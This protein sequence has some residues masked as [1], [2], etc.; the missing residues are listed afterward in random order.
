MEFF[1][2]DARFGGDAVGGEGGDELAE[3]VVVGG[4]GVDV[5]LVDPAFG[6]EDVGKAVEEGEVGFGLERDV[7]GG[8][9]RGFGHAR[10]DDDDLGVV[11]VASD[12]LPEDRV[13]NA[14][15]RADEDDDV[16]LL[17][18]LVG[19]GR[20]VEAERLFVGDGGRGH[21]LAGVAVAVD[22]AHAE[23]GEATEVGHLFA[24]DLTRAEK[25]DRLGAVLALDRLEVDAEGLHRFCPVD[26]LEPT[27]GIF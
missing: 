15:V 13:G 14:K 8:G 20:G 23:F 10:V 16:G 2:G 5:V 6:D 3:I 18:V 25:G 21:A 22:D 1:F 12:A 4:V 9:H 19:V 26:W 17:E 11:G 27:P 24:G 7:L